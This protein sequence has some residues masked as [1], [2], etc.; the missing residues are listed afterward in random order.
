[1]FVQLNC[2]IID[3]DPANRQELA[4]FLGQYGL[5]VVAQ[6]PACDTL[7]TLLNRGDAPQLI[8]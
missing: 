1:M 5:N 6:F 4:N 2:I 8:R 7:P 3:A